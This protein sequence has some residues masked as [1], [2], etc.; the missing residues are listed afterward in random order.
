MNK[1]FRNGQRWPESMVLR[2]WPVLPWKQTYRHEF[3][4]AFFMRLLGVFSRLAF[5]VCP[6]DPRMVLENSCHWRQSPIFIEF[7][8][9]AGHGVAPLGKRPTPS[10]CARTRRVFTLSGKKPLCRLGPALNVGLP[11]K[12]FDSTASL[13]ASFE[14]DCGLNE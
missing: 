7:L 11:V 12:L 14:V 10:F 4:R 8:S 1:A 5:H 3:L 13:F 9:R 2:D 6:H